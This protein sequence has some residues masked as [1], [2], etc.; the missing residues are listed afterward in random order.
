[1][2][3]HLNNR[4]GY[5]KSLRRF[6]NGQVTTPG[7]LEKHLSAQDMDSAERL[8]HTLK[9]IAGTI[10]AGALQELSGALESA[11]RG[12]ASVAQ[13][14]SLAA[15]L[16]A[17]LQRLLAAIAS[18]LPVQHAEPAVETIPDTQRIATLRPCLSRLNA[19]LADFDTD[20]IEFY[21][22][23]A[24]DLRPALGKHAGPVE[25]A[26]TRYDFREAATLLNTIPWVTKALS[27]NS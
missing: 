11:I 13:C 27:E 26:L 17:E 5:E 1:M 4:A 14:A 16:I 19:L 25:A 18:A 21:E 3:R 10:G 15:P 22:A 8:A 9:G 20:A 23:H 12:R 6:Q 7:E 24:T 2:R